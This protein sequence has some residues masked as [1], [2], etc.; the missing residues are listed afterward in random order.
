MSDV[1]VLLALLAAVAGAAA[2][3]ARSPGRGLG[4]RLA[5]GTAGLLVATV[6]VVITVGLVRLGARQP[7]PEA[8]S[9]AHLQPD[10]QRGERLAHLCAECHADDG[11]LPLSGG[12]RNFS[13]PLGRL[14]APNL[15]PA[16]RIATWTDDQVIAAIRHGVDAQGRPLLLMPSAAYAGLSDADVAALVAFLR[17]Q[18][19]VANDVPPRR[20]NALGAAVV[21][22]GVFPTSADRARRAPAEDTHV[23]GAHAAALAGCA[24][25]HGDDLAG[26]DPGGFVPTGPGLGHVGREWTGEA[27]VALFRSGTTPDGRAIDADS[28]PWRS[29]GRAFTD[30]E[31]RDLHAYVRATT[32]RGP[33]PSDTDGARIYAERCSSCHGGEGRGPRAP[34]LARNRRVADAS[35]LIGRILEGG[36]GMPAWSAVLGDDEIAAVATHVRTNWGND[37]GPIDTTTVARERSLRD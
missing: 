23:R 8:P 22:L 3:L 20:L 6:A 13:P 11:E 1:A 25:C 17:A 33:A 36:R 35:F 4:L 2:L 24:D 19:A 31:L 28:M 21:G 30:G 32:D 5:A 12:S 27:F 18:R 16:G 7:T 37:H 29:V 26:G 34:S 15:T 10:L 9:L 14:Y